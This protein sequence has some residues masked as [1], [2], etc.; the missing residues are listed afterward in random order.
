MTDG[1]KRITRLLASLG[2]I[3]VSGSLLTASPS[4]AE[5]NIEDVQQRVESLYHQAEIAS[6]R[7]N[8][9]RHDMEQGKARLKSLRADLDRKEQQVEEIR[10]QVVSSILAQSQGQ[11]FSSA[12]QVAVSEDP[13]AF[14][15]RLVVVSQYNEQQNQVK[16]QFA[17]QIKQLELRQQAAKRELTQIASAKEELAT[18][19]ATIDDK[20]AEAK[21]LLTRLK[22][23]AAARAAARASRDLDRTPVAQP[24]PTPAPAPAPTASV[25]GRAGAAVDF[26]L[27]QVGDA[28]VW[29]ATG[30]DAFDCSG[31]TMAAWQQAGVSLPHSSSSQMSSGTSVSSDSLQPGDL[32]FYY[33]PVSHVGIYI[34]N[35]QIVHAAN[36]SDGVTTAPVFSMPY[37]GAVRPG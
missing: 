29:G 20:A 12:T 3:A 34:G 11:A 15:E 31:L 9:V 8:E 37:S 14:L 7:Y 21:Q 25:S 32:V 22:D 6:E 13:D 2:L 23:E 26:A 19:K 30:P 17:S 36:P 10:Q 28:Y 5:P 24:A 33:S 16:S 35:G 1:R 18:Q 4:S 27:A